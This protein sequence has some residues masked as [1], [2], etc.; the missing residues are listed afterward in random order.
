MGALGARS[1][2]PLSLGAQSAFD[3]PVEFGRP[4]RDYEEADSLMPAGGF[5]S[6]HESCAAIYRDFGDCKRHTLFDSVQKHCGSAG[7]EAPVRRQHVP[8]SNHGR[9]RDDAW[10]E[11]FVCSFSATAAFRSG[12]AFKARTMQMVGLGC[13]NEV[14]ASYEESTRRA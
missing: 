1:T 7:R 6:G 4:R 8:P 13:A 12:S 11:R 3:A 2:F 9:P 14:L 10:P 5:V